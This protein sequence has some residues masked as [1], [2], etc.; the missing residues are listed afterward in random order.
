LG[1]F[2]PKKQKKVEYSSS[3]DN[4]SITVLGCNNDEFTIEFVYIEESGDNGIDIVQSQ[5]T[6][7]NLIVIN[8]GEDALNMDSST[9]TVVNTLILLVPLT[10]IYD[11]D[12]F[13]FEVDTG[14]SVLK[15]NQY[16]YVE[17]LGIFGDQT[18]LVSNDLPPPTEGVYIYKGVTKNGQSYIYL[19]FSLNCNNS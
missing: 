5:I 4:D 2:D 8:P 17:I 3:T 11:R 9:L 6:I 10:K 7:N 14:N 19:N 16:C 18:T 13:D 15:I 1:S 12:I